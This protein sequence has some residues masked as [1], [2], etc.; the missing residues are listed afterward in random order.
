ML[1]GAAK[2]TV[3][4]SRWNGKFDSGIID[5]LA[6]LTAQVFYSAGSWLRNV[7]TGFLRTY[8]LFLAVGA[9]C[10]FFLLTLV[11]SMVNAG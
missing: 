2:G 10:L 5:G 11:L 3:S 8:I 1:H 9:V 4:V 6:N 7:Q